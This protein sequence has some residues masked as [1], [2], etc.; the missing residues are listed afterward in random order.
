[1][2]KKRPWWLNLA[3]ISFIAM[4]I[5]RIFNKPHLFGKILSPIL[6]N[7]VYMISLFLLTIIIL[8]LY[9]LK[10]W[11]FYL[12]LID[13]GIGF[14]NHIVVIIFYSTG[15]NKLTGSLYILMTFYWL[16]LA[17]FIY[18]NKRIFK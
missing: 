7:I 12:S 3:I 18:K 4:L 1:M 11:G 16:V 13:I 14:V 10:K 8:G 6:T 17:Y 2:M 5:F 9:L 15:M